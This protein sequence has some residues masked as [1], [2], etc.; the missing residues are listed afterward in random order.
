MECI[1]Y[2]IEADNSDMAIKYINSI[3][4]ISQVIKLRAFKRKNY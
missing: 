2:L 1:N 3:Y 4:F